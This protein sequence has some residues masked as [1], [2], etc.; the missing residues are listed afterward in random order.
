[1]STLF[2]LHLPTL[3]EQVQSNCAISDARYA[4]DYSLCIYLLRMR[5]FYRWRFNIPLTQ[6]LNTNSVGEW[7][8]RMEF[9]WDDIEASEFEPITLHDK[10][11]EPFDSAAIN[12]H[13]A[14][15]GLVY[16]A[17]YGRLGQPH[18][19]LAK[20]I[21]QHTDSTISRFECGEELARDSITMPAMTQ[22]HTVFIRHDSIKRH[23]WQMIDEWRLKKPAGPLARIADHYQLL[24]LSIAEVQL[25]RC[26]SD[27]SAI[28]REHE[29]GE[30]AAGE[31]LGEPYHHLLQTSM[32]TRNEFYLR[33]IRDI[34]AD[35][36]T[37]W[38]Y[39]LKKHS[40]IELD[41]WLASVTGARL[42]LLKAAEI[43]TLLDEQAGEQDGSRFERLKRMLENQQQ[44]WLMLAEQVITEQ[45]LQNKK[46]DVKT[47]ALSFLNATLNT[48]WNTTA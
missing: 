42:E 15:N 27:L 37:T 31:L 34:L 44:R 4:R 40:G 3:C 43:T 5:E 32:G 26:A 47:Q 17:G 7:I 46:V 45:A 39:L 33:A 12:D 6:R 10:S 21:N 23:I 48:T 14:P 1:M 16:S 24:D 18:F 29:R 25:E 20:L 13:L 35:T 22:K 36:L 28:Y 41:F 9:H 38:P 19:V 8:S 30:V 11:F 2:E